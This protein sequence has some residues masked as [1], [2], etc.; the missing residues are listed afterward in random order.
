MSIAVKWRGHI[1]SPRNP[2]LFTSLW[3]YSPPNVTTGSVAPHALTD[4]A[5]ADRGRLRLRKPWT[6]APVSPT[7]SSAVPS[8]GNTV[9]STVS[10]DSMRV[11][12]AL[13]GSDFED[14]LL[15]TD[16]Y[17]QDQEHL[18]EPLFRAHDPWSTHS[19]SRSPPIRLAEMPLNEPV[20]EILHSTNSSEALVNTAPQ[21][22]DV[23]GA[24]PIV[25]GVASTSHA[26]VGMMPTRSDT[27]ATYYS[28]PLPQ[29][30]PYHS[31]AYATLTS[32][33]PWVPAGA[34]P[35]GNNY[36]VGAAAPWI[37]AV[38]PWAPT[39][40]GMQAATSISVPT[41]PANHV[42]G[43]IWSLRDTLLDLAR[44]GLRL[45]S[46]ALFFTFQETYLILLFRLPK[47]Y[48]SRVRKVFEDA[49]LSK[50]DIVRIY[51]TSAREWQERGQLGPDRSRFNLA[52]LPAPSWNP[53]GTEV[54][55]MTPAV[56]AFKDSWESFIKSLLQEWSTL[57]II[58]ALLSASILALL[59]V[60]GTADDPVTRTACIT[61]LMCSLWSIVYASMYIVRFGTMSKMHKAASWAEEAQRKT[62]LLWNV[63]ALLAMPA[64]WLVWSLLS[65]M[66]AIMSYVWRSNSVTD[67]ASRTTSVRAS[68]ATR[69]A[70]TCVLGIGI[71]YFFAMLNTLR[72]YGEVMDETW[73]RKMAKQANKVW[74]QQTGNAAP[75]RDSRAAPSSIQSYNSPFYYRNVITPRQGPFPI[76]TPQQ[77]NLGRDT[78]GITYGNLGV[79]GLSNEQSTALPSPT[80]SNY[81]VPSPEPSEHINIRPQT[82][83]RRPSL[84]PSA[85]SPM[86]R[87]SSTG[88]TVHWSP[89]AS[90][91]PQNSVTLSAI[92]ERTEPL[93]P[94]IDAEGA[95][96]SERA[97]TVPLAIHAGGH[98]EDASFPAFRA[99]ELSR[100][101]S[102]RIAMP[103]QLSKRGYMDHSWQGF[104][105]D[106]QAAWRTGFISEWYATGHRQRSRLQ[107]SPQEACIQIC[108]A[109]TMTLF[110][111]RVRPILC[112]ERS[113]S[114]FS[115]YSVYMLDSSA[116]DNPRRVFR[117]IPDGIREIVL[118]WEQPR[119]WNDEVW[120]AWTIRRAE[121]DTVLFGPD[122]RDREAN[123]S[124]VANDP[125]STPVEP[126]SL[127]SEIA[128]VIHASTEV[129]VSTI[130]LSTVLSE[131]PL[132]LDSTLSYTNRQEREHRQVSEEPEEPEVHERHIEPSES[133]AHRQP[134]VTPASL[135]RGGT[136]ATSL[137]DFALFNPPGAVHLQA[138][139]THRPIGGQETQADLGPAYSAWTVSRRRP[140]DTPPEHTSSNLSS[141]SSLALPVP[142]QRQGIWIAADP[143]TQERTQEH[144]TDDAGQQQS[145]A[146]QPDTC[147]QQTTTGIGNG[148]HD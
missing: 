135:A 88:K 118:L 55:E 36:W 95:G 7:S 97:E 113:R 100:A 127:G 85:Q 31:P 123:L 56:A 82:P 61:S 110:R 69:I 27:L 107:V 94:S 91:S 131:S 44:R 104:V 120:K 59:S 138:D 10:P 130:I 33:G 108:R 99:I 63:W 92:S 5:V 54:S 62:G 64:V 23:Q 68:L 37:P 115:N 4:R 65:F 67:P 145:E 148:A 125:D 8:S 15:E 84:R 42:N 35:P 144:L 66:V 22:L 117:G 143:A 20:P 52:R 122:W 58:S 21:H 28:Q 90:D 19:R 134:Q 73:K 24:P 12:T 103:Q 3:M 137:S 119:D 93:I 132:S 14:S 140:V 87:R 13:K 41:K 77:S 32:P 74:R 51:T 106:L 126:P 43:S 34:W 76:W 116:I 53:T 98:D 133:E 47:V 102:S 139:L 80:P 17:A 26:P 142:P 18:V 16:E 105:E 50:P 6:R 75:A 146:G 81:V 128:P 38:T 46:R 9:S 2:D 72:R 70:V 83:Q 57:N 147:D 49:E 60:D 25:P 111:Y 121:S 1:G 136:G 30:S 71:L 40:T 86:P 29:L 109:W 48:F 79:S 96:V 129:T 112:E 78:T 101:E 39:V 141:L 114:G 45:G 124:G 11:S 89:V